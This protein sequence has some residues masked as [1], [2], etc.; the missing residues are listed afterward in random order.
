MKLWTALSVLFFSPALFAAALI[1]GAGA[2]FP[3]PLYAKW[4]SEYQKVNPEV[5]INYQSIG[6]GGGI[7]QFSQKTVDFGA[8]DAPM[9]DEQIKEAK[10]PV[11]HI[12]TVLGAVV[13]TYNVPEVTKPLQLS[14]DL[15]ADIFL[16]TITKWDDARI[17]AQNPGVTL[18]AKAILVAHRSD[19]SG[20]TNIFTDYLSKVSPAWKEKVG[21]GTAVKWPTGLG[22]KGNEGVAGLVKQTPGAVGYVE[23]IYAKSNDLKF[24]SIKNKAGAFVE[25]DMKSVTAAAGATKIPA[26]F[27][28]SLT[29]ASG[30]GAYPISGFTYLL[31]W[32]KHPDADKGGKLVEFLNWAVTDGQ[33][34]AGDLHYA[35][36]PSSLVPKVQ[37]AIKTLDAKPAAKAKG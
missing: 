36:L 5:Q 24:A 11:V 9:T 22:G 4:F 19:G 21:V 17:K 37:G 25:P 32:K 13:V 20:T 3:Y 15:V 1:N 16:G 33:K 28:V 8:S 18:P 7:R 30:K 31:V 6:S 29:D 34:Y 2:S 10:E 23:L 14:G 12:P 26:D 35:P 27:R